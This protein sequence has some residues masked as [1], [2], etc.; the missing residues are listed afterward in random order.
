MSANYFPVSKPELNVAEYVEKEYLKDLKNVVGRRIRE[1]EFRESDVP[2]VILDLGATLTYLFHTMGD[3]RLQYEVL[4]RN[5]DPVEI[6]RGKKRLTE[7]DK[8]MGKTEVPLYD[9]GYLNISETFGKT[10]DTSF[11]YDPRALYKA[12]YM[13]FD[14][15]LPPEEQVI[16][17]LI[18]RSRGLEP[19]IEDRIEVSSSPVIWNRLRNQ[20]ALHV[21]KRKENKL[22]PARIL[23]LYAEKVEN[24]EYSNRLLEA[25]KA[26]NKSGKKK[27]KREDV[28]KLI[29]DDAFGDLLFKVPEKV[30]MESFSRDNRPRGMYD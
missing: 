7:K 2:S 13:A 10:W 21:S 14:A 29:N 30:L 9:S 28:R 15:K 18:Y 3:S 19:E 4:V 24:A 26:A 6:T 11:P 27:L 20:I 17:N 23:K 8:A 5:L 12:N 16:P 25:L 22:C 1:R